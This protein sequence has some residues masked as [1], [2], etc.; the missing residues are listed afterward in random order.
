MKGA[1]LR[2]FYGS[3]VATVIL[4]A[5]ICRSSSITE[6]ERKKLDKVIRK[7]RRVLGCPLDSVREVT[8]GSWL[9]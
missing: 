5:M 4:Y 8:E 9:N 6:R 1:L 7:S 3:V 2:T